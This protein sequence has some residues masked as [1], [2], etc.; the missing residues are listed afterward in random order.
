MDSDWPLEI[1]THCGRSGVCGLSITGN[2]GIFYRCCQLNCELNDEWSLLNE[3][4]WVCYYF[5]FII[6]VCNTIK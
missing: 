5:L 2:W 4:I 3:D 6:F 1:E